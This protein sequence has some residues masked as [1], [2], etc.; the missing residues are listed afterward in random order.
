MDM[1]LQFKE[2]ST[3]TEWDRAHYSA[4]RL[5]SLET[6]DVFSRDRRQAGQQYLG[7]RNIEP[8]GV[9]DKD[10]EGPYTRT[11]LPFSVFP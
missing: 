10:Q 1:Q 9:V 3:W 6:K 11:S 2:Q 7:R 8:V 5:S 4:C